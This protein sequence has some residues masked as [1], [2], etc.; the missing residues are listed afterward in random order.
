MQFLYTLLLTVVFS[1]GLFA[2]AP[3]AFKFQAVARDDGNNPLVS[4]N[5][6]VRVSLLRGS[7]SGSL[8]YSERHELVTTA[9]GVFDLQVG[10]GDVLSGDMSGIDWGGDSYYLKV[11]ID[12]GG[13]TNYVNM[14]ATQLLSVPYALYAANAEGGS[15]DQQLTLSGTDLSIEDGN[16]VDLSTLQ[17]GVDDADADP[18][19][20]IQQL[21]LN[22]NT[23]SLTDG[24]DVDLS[25]YLNTALWTEGSNNEISYAG[26]GVGIRV[27]DPEDG[28]GLHLGDDVFLQSNLGAFIIGYP[29]NGNRW[30]L[31]TQK[32]GED[33]LFRSKPE[34]QNSYNSRFNF[35]QDGKLVVNG[36]SATGRLTIFQEGQSLGTGLVFDDGTANEVWHVTHGFGLRFHYGNSLRAT[37]SANNGAYIQGSDRKLKRDIADLGAVTDR[38]M[39]LRPTTYLYKNVENATS[40][41]G[42]VAQE[43]QPVFP[44]LVHYMEADDTYGLNYAGFGVIAVKAIQEQQET[45][46]AQTKQIEDL[47]A[48][49][50]R[51]EAML[52]K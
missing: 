36:T 27:S 9:L 29:D 22:G 48:R 14:G 17:D 47:E 1:A 21:S 37:I 35:T 52:G 18:T 26:G 23:L 12:P 42:F 46:D 28:M 13:G 20:E 19:N 50:A 11:D 41:I 25:P 44:E 43:V 4:Q 3:A 51:L 30:R 33:L 5:I 40:T 49:L 7:D 8:E 15:D 34:G 10:G 39:R 38:L 2:Q 16:S 32:S 6:G 31:A 45:I 24:G